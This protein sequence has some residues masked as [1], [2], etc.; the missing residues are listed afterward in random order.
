ML[1]TARQYT[2]QSRI[3]LDDRLTLLGNSAAD[4][5]CALFTGAAVYPLD[6]QEVGIAH[7]AG[8]LMREEITVYNSVATLFR[9]LVGTL[10]GGEA[11]PALRLI[12]LQGEPVQWRDVAHFQ[13]HFA[14]ACVLVNSYAVMETGLVARSFPGSG[15]SHRGGPVAR[16]PS[17]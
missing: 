2:N 12:Q 3:S 9:Q 15:H 14:P 11:F 7:L 10:T 17:S 16:W 13:Q 5:F 1:R 8:W 4:I 6:V